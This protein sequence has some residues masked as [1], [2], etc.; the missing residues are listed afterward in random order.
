VTA[1]LL[2]GRALLNPDHG[3]LLYL[4]GTPGLRG[5][6]ENQFAGT[7]SVLLIAEERKYLA[8]R[9]AGLVQPGFAGFVEIG[10]LAGGPPPHAARAV[11]ADAG[12]GFRL[13]NLKASGPSVVKVDVAVPIGESW[14][15]GRAARLV[16]GFRREL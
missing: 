2:E 3:V 7:R 1:V 10:A 6:A 9:P 5:F 16:V 14:R 11:H 15:G 4:G 13:A 12:V 8:W